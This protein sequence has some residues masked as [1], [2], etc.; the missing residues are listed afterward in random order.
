VVGDKNIFIEIIAG[1]IDLI[2]ASR[3]IFS[4]GRSVKTSCLGKVTEWDSDNEK[5]ILKPIAIY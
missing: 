3:N 2:P 4:L 1:E 5:L